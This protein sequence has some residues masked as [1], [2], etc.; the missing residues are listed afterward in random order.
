MHLFN[1][2]GRKRYKWGKAQIKFQNN[3]LVYDSGEP[4]QLNW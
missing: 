1:V 2:Q 4:G 3:Q